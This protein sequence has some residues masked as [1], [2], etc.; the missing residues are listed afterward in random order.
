MPSKFE[1]DGV[2]WD[3][4][5]I[6]RIK[7]LEISCDEMRGGVMDGRQREKRRGKKEGGM[8]KKFNTRAEKRTYMKTN[9]ERCFLMLE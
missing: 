7:R 8:E 9:A 3:F 4:E 1:L 2:S 6:I 5:A